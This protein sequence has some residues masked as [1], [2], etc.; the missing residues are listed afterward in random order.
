MP[1]T[2]INY[3]H[4]FPEKVYHCPCL[5]NALDEILMIQMCIA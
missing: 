5:K 2:A 3:E 1:T 4:F